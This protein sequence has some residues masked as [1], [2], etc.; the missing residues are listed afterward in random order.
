MQLTGPLI[1]DNFTARAD[2]WDIAHRNVQT[3]QK[4]PLSMAKYD[5]VVICFDIADQRNLESVAKVI[6][7]ESS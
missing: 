6:T 1:V 3:G 2:I 7:L 5:V 4:H